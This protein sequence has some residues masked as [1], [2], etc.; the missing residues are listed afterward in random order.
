M[1]SGP[2]RPT[3]DVRPLVHTIWRS[4]ILCALAANVVAGC[5]TYVPVEFSTPEPG[6]DVRADM[7][8]AGARA[9]VPRFGPGVQELQGMALSARQDSISVLVNAIQTRQGTMAVDGQPIRLAPPDVTRVYER[10]LSRT[11]SVLLGAGLLAAAV[12]LVEGFA[13]AGRQ[14]ETDDV[15]P[16]TPPAV[17]MPTNGGFGLRIGW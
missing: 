2:A 3:V 1:F 5:Y 17:R 10:R 13:N 11:R 14:L 16:I 15:D 8:E 9:L 6:R 7:T 12:V 4:L